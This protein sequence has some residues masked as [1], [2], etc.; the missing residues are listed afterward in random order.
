MLPYGRIEAVYDRNKDTDPVVIS[1]PQSIAGIKYFRFDNNAPKGVNVTLVPQG[2]PFTVD[3]Y[4]RPAA[5]VNTA[6]VRENGAIVS[7][8]EGSFK[9]GSLNITP[10]MEQTA[11]DF[12]IPLTVRDELVGEW[13]LFFTFSSEET[14]TVCEFQ[15]FEL[16]CG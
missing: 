8:G 14:G 10:D 16:Y 3:V 6:I 12:L 5:A 13:G 9:A 11:T 2:K 15:S 1:G 4:F 7:V